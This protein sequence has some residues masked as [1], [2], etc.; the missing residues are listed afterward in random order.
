[1]YEDFKTYV[2]QHRLFAQNDRILVAVSGGRDSM[3]LLDCLLNTGVYLE[4]AH[5]NYHLR[6]QASDQDEQLVSAY[7]DNHNIRCHILSTD[8]NT[9]LSEHNQNLQAL[10]REVRY[11]YFKEIAELQKLDL[12]A[13]AHHMDDRIENYFISSLRGTGLRG[14][15]SMKNKNDQIIRPLLFASRNLINQHLKT[16]NIPYRDDASNEENKYQRNFIRNKILLAIQD[17]INDY[18]IR[19]L[20]TMANLDADA[21]LFFHLI[22]EKKAQMSK[23]VKGHIVISLQDFINDP[24]T[25]NLYYHLLSPYGLNQDQVDSLLHAHTGISIKT[26]KYEVLRDRSQL[27][28]RT[29]TNH[30][31]LP[32]HIAN[33]DL[34]TT[35]YSHHLSIIN[36]PEFDYNDKCLYLDYQKLAFPLLIRPWESGDTFKPYGLKGKSKKVKDFLTNKK[37]SSYEKDDTLVLCSGSDI[38]AI[39][40]LEVNYHWRVLE[41]S[42][43]ILRIQQQ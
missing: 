24:K 7:C 6:A 2:S 4:V 16:K 31:Y 8:L 42:T 18:Q 17:K 39:I 23:T 36:A 38:V 28:I 33:T 5:I 9:K 29:I 11:T 13:L 30:T 34:P 43:Q 32:Q 41:N 1:M 37:L 10:A 25:L 35:I 19:M 12:I 3:A 40:G 21:E 26:T 15:T 22:E 27:I 14:I 20:R